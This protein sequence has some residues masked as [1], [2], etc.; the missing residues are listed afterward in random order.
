LITVI[1]SDGSIRTYQ[2]LA[3][4]RNLEKGTVVGTQGK[5]HV[6]KSSMF[7][8]ETMLDFQT[9]LLRCNNSLECSDLLD[10]SFNTGMA[11]QTISFPY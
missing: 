1:G 6:K 9:L 11:Q 8:A 5:P 3:I 2:S 4:E 7:G 10:N